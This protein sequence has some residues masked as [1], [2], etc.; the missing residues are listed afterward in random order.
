MKKKKME[1]EQIA[2]GINE[3]V[4]LAK[5][6]KD[7]KSFLG[8]LRRA[9]KWLGHQALRFCLKQI[10]RVNDFNIVRCRNSKDRIRCF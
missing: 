9:D 6:T 4:H 1:D 7:P 2:A 3:Q 10:S 8:I 5:R